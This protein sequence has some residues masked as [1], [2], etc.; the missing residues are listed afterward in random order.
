MI[1]DKFDVKR[2]TDGMAFGES[3]Q[4]HEG[5]LYVSDMIGKRLYVVSE[6]GHK[7]V[8][9]ETP[10]QVNG[11]A[12]D[13]ENH[14]IYGTMFDKQLWSYNP[15]DGKHTHFA[16]MSN[17]MS[18]YTG[19]MVTDSKGRVYVDDVG[20]RVLHG[21]EPRPG[22]IL[23]V[24]A[25]GK[26]KAAYED[27]LFPNGIGIDSTGKFLFL[28]ETYSHALVRFDIGSDG[29][30]S[31]RSVIWNI[32]DY[33]VS[34]GA[35]WSQYNSGDGLCIDGEDC[36]WMSMLHYKRFIR[37]N[38]FTGIITDQINVQGDAT[39]C[40]LGGSDGKTLYMVVNEIPSEGNFFDHMTQGRTKCTIYT[41]RVEIPKGDARS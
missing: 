9:L 32:K 35:E 27:L 31:K 7:D 5:L 23:L 6:A 19:D 25:D 2:L 13:N 41:T 10:N 29:M 14:L 39:A 12:F 24:E 40:C 30:L 20:A 1:H 4:W 17:L 37:L 21:E 3:P 16:D 38:P 36:I 18:G 28:I 26:V 22:R 33:P 11:S 34:S 8:V 15:T